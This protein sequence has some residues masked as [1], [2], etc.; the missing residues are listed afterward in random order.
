M[1]AR[2]FEEEQWQLKL[3][4]LSQIQERVQEITDRARSLRLQLTEPVRERAKERFG[5]FLDRVMPPASQQAATC[6]SCGA[7]PLKG[8][9]FC[10]QCG[11]NLTHKPR[12]FRGLSVEV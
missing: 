3:E 9:R 10:P 5:Q 4:R 11:T 6:P 7:E 2:Q 1:S 12:P 8:A